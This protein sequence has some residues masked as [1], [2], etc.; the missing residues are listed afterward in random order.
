MRAFDML[1]VT[2]EELKLHSFAFDFEVNKDGPFHGFMSWFDVSF[3]RQDAESV[4]LS[5]SPG[6]P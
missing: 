5:T 3:E 2:V 6:L 4:V 1:T